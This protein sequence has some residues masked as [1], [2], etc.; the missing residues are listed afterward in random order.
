MNHHSSHVRLFLRNTLHVCLDLH[1]AVESTRSLANPIARPS[2]IISSTVITRPCTIQ[3]GAVQCSLCSEPMAQTQTLAQPHCSRSVI[4]SCTLSQYAVPGLSQL[5]CVSQSVCCLSCQL[6]N[7]LIRS[8][9]DRELESP[10]CGQVA[11]LTTP[12]NKKK[13]K[14]REKKKRRFTI[15][16]ISGADIPVRSIP[17]LVHPSHDDGRTS[18]YHPCLSYLPTTCLPYLQTSRPG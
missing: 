4:A 17:C 7:A 14:K 5:L 9:R 15:P 18:S 11:L 6:S 8:S 13:K 12:C 1:L 16:R 2:G 10:Q 3:W